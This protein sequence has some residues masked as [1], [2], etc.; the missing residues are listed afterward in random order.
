MENLIEL[1]QYLKLNIH[2]FQLNSLGEKYLLDQ[3]HIIDLQ[4]NINIQKTIEDIN[5][6]CLYVKTQYSE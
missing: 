6:L 1:I 3:L 5:N 2:D 4:N